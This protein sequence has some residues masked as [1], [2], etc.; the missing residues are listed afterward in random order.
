ML[1]GHEVVRPVCSATSS[2]K[3][4]TQ[5]P[6]NTPCLRS[7]AHAGPLQTARPIPVMAL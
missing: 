7:Q 6:T 5:G 1:L 4:W 3:V 2:E